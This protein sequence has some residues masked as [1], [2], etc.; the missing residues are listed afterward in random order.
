M[1]ADAGMEKKF[2]GEAIVNTCYLQNILPTACNERT[3]YELWY[4]R[5]PSYKH[6]RVSG[7]VAYVFIPKQQ[8]RKLD[9]KAN[10]MVLVGYAEGR[11]VYRFLGGL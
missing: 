10:K 3:S 2:W 5:K 8:R 1:L 4:G 7:S 6:L 9:M 11:K